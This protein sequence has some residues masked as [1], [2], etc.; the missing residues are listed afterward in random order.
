V[1]DAIARRLTETGT[2]LQNACHSEAPQSVEALEQGVGI[3]RA[4]LVVRPGEPVK[5]HSWPQVRAS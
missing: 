5:E 4:R 3:R 2:D 1:S